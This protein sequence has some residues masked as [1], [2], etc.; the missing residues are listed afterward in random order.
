MA[1]NFPNSPTNG[2]IFSTSTNVGTITY[3]Y[4]STAQAW[5][6]STTSTNY[7]NINIQEITAS[8]NQNTF[9]VPGG[10]VIGQ[11][12]VF[13]N[14]VQ[15]ASA[16]YTANDSVNVVT[17]IPR[18]SGD[19]MR[20]VSFSTLWGVTNANAFSINEVTASTNNQTVFTVSYNTG[21]TLVSLNGVQ[22]NS[23]DYTASN[24]TSITLTSGVGVQAGHIL[25][26]VSF[27]NVNLSGAL[28]LSGGTINGNLSVTGS[29]LVKNQSISGQS[30]AM[31]IAL[32]A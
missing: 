30:A 17:A 21:T 18:N 15:L 31:A 29:L 26:V 19:V 7:A 6:I 5:R 14:G 16:D 3:V 9:S 25:R 32:G 27:N 2:Q 23:A 13:A 4:N 28:P 22:L 8:A 10:Y 11:L 12:A 24:G 20:F 1:I